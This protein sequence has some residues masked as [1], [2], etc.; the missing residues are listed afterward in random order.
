[1]DGKDLCL[2]KIR[3]RGHMQ[4]HVDLVCLKFSIIC[5]LNDFRFPVYLISVTVPFL[6]H[7]IWALNSFFGKLWK[8]NYQFF[9]KIQSKNFEWFFRNFES[10]NLI[11]YFYQYRNFQFNQSY[12]GLRLELQV[13][14]PWFLVVILNCTQIRLFCFY[15]FIL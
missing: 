8:L 7:F 6:V 5:S 3:S 4:W 10:C 12:L 1:M 11:F 9:L 2:L 13:Q 15:E 14:K